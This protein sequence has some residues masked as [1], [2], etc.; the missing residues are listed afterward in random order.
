MDNELTIH[1]IIK[2]YIDS[3]APII[4]SMALPI[5]IVLVVFILRKNIANLI[6]KMKNIRYKG[7]EVDLHKDIKQLNKE[8][9][10][11]VLPNTGNVEDTDVIY[12]LAE[13]SVE[14]A[15]LMS[16]KK[17]E[18]KLLEFYENDTN[19]DKYRKRPTPRI[20]AGYL[21]KEKVISPN[22]YHVIIELNHIRNESVHIAH[23]KQL[24]INMTA[25]EFNNLV[26]KVI[27]ELNAI[28]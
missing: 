6:S 12:Q 11:T 20:I 2:L 17:L 19:K 25:I 9:E 27:A 15:I 3:I 21:L 7:V 13:I 24:N 1:E 10:P 23:N 22:L 14:S 8:F 5:A 28:K 4:D 26:D 16:W 18:S